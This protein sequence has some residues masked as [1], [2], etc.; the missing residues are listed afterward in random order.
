MTD[1]S[2]KDQVQRDLHRDNDDA[3]NRLVDYGSPTL[4]S[5]F[6]SKKSRR[7]SSSSS[8]VGSSFEFIVVI[9]P[10]SFAESF[11]GS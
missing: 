6:T 9:D 1:V 3:P 11:L 5:S 10:G 4:G 8:V 2:W 7:S